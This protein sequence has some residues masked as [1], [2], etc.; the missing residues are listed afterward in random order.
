MFHLLV[1]MQGQN[2]AG[3]AMAERALSC[4]QVPAQL[5]ER[6]SKHVG[7]GAT[8]FARSESRLCKVGCPTDSDLPGKIPQFG[9]FRWPTAS[10]SQRPTLRAP[11]VALVLFDHVIAASIEGN[12]LVVSRSPVFVASRAADCPLSAWIHMRLP[13]SSPK[14]RG[15]GGPELHGSPRYS[16]GACSCFFHTSV[17]CFLRV[18][19]HAV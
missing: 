14:K 6:K 13:M 15:D 19:C 9:P 4:F 10:F 12:G 7:F 8:Q 16:V 18:R 11:H 3:P 1:F 17:F 5:T 2:P